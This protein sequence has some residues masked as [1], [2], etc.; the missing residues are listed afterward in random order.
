[1]MNVDLSPGLIKK[2]HREA[3]SADGQ[4]FF[5]VLAAEA[6]ARRWFLQRKLPCWRTSRQPSDACRYSLVFESG[7][8]AIVTPSGRRRISFDIM[9]KARCEYLL[10][11][12][13]KDDSSGYV[14]GFFYLFDIRKPGNIDWRPDLKVLCLREM[15]SFPELCEKPD[16]FRLSY[17]L[18]SLRLLITGD[19]KAPIP[20]SGVTASLGNNPQ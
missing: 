19:P 9:A 11:V 17:F 8:R 5:D 3:A 2:L 18:S 20:G 16:H 1:M 7:R 14:D 13:M 15:E 12:E 6:I 10:T 4:D